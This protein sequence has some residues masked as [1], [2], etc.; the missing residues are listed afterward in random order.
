MYKHILVPI[1]NSPADEAILQHI[2]PLARMTG[3]RL[4][5][6]HVAEGY[7]ARTQDALDLEDSEEIRED[8]AY[9]QRRQAE[10][11]GE[12]F[13][14]AMILERGEPVDKIL[15]VAEREGCD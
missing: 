14:A 3:G 6:L 11:A 9:L 8:R 1:D 10:L 7:A 2:R 4:T 5:L 15:E 13:Q 12:G